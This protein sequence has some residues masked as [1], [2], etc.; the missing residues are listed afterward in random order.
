MGVS[1]GHFQAA[2]QPIRQIGRGGKARPGS[3]GQALGL[4]LHIPH[5]AGCG[6]KRQGQGFGGIENAFLVFL[7]IL[8]IGQRQALHHRHQPHQRAD[9]TARLAAHQFRR[10]GVALLRHDGTA[11]GEGIRQFHKAEIGVGPDHDFFRQAGQMRVAHGA[12]EQ[13][14]SGEIA[15]CHGIQAVPH[16]P[17]K[18]QSL[19]GH[20]PVN[21]EART[22]QSRRTKWAFIQPRPAIREA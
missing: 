14:F 17:I 16:G 13:E 18:A 1:E 2:H 19:G 12:A 21:R 8:E 20:V 10:I 3:G 9:H 5:H 22:R 6:S 15:R 4:G 11:R 7:H